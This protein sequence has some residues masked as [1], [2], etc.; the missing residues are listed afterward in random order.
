VPP[1]S[2]SF[3]RMTRLVS[4]RASN[5]MAMQSPPKP[6]PTIATS[7]FVSSCAGLCPW[8]SHRSNLMSLQTRL[9]GSRA[10]EGM[11]KGTGHF[12]PA[13]LLPVGEY[14]TYRAGKAKF[15]E[16][17]AIAA[18]RTAAASAVRGLAAL[19]PAS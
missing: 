9:Y 7:T 1:I 11:E 17:S 4:P 18:A 13:P 5:L 10:P 2:V 3:S 8:F 16:R 19:R 15:D 12:D 6:A 14:E